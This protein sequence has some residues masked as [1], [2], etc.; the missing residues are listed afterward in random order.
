[1]SD[2]DRIKLAPLPA[3]TVEELSELHD[4][5]LWRMSAL[6]QVRTMAQAADIIE[7]CDHKGRILQSLDT[8]VQEAR[9]SIDR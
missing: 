8:A 4:A 7:M 1:M 9:M 6:A 2:S 5:I 3:L